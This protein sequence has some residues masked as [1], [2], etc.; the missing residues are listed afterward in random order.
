[1][2]THAF[3][4][5]NGKLSNADKGVRHSC[6]QEILFKA[7]TPDFNINATSTWQYVLQNGP[8]MIFHGYAW[9]LDTL[10]DFAW[11]QLGSLKT[12]LV[13]LLVAEVRAW[14]AL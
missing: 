10:V 3:C 11:E 1:M 6:P 4:F 13:V 5:L 8:S 12:V 7:V 2:N 14:W 9:S